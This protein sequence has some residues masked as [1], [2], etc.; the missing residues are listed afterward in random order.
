MKGF[1]F[2]GVLALGILAG[3]CGTGSAS[4]QPVISGDY[5][6]ESTSVICS[7]LGVCTLNFTAT[8]STGSRVLV[9][10]LNCLVFRA[11]GNVHYHLL[12]IRDTVSANARRVEYLPAGVLS[13]SSDGYRHYALTTQTDFLIAPG[14][15][16]SVQAIQDPG[17]GA[18]LNC[19]ITGRLQP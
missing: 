1:S 2:S 13:T 10:K 17:S 8:P 16:P 15:I 3:V 6:E 11:P 4:A 9:T 19:K 14:K 7:T 5:Y 18:T 12:G